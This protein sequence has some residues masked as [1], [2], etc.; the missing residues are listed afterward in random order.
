M[1][2]YLCED[3]I[4][5]IGT[6]IGKGAIGIVRISGKES[7]RILKE[8]FRSVRGKKIENFEPRKLYLGFVVDEFG[9]EIDQVLAVYMQ[10]PKSFT[11]EDLVEIHSH[12]GVVVV[13]KIL[14]EVLKR[15]ARLAEPGEFTMRAFI[16]GKIDLVQAEAINQLIEAKSEL[17]AEVA[18]KQLEGE[19]S[20]EIERI[21]DELLEVKAYIEAAVDFPEEEVEIIESGKV[22]EKLIEV[23]EKIEKLLKSYREGKIIKEG[24]KVAI[25]GRP[26]VGKSSLLNALLAEERAI[27]TEIP[28]TTRDVIEESITVKGIPLVLIDTAGIRETKELVEKIGIERSIEKLKESDVILFV[29][30]GSAELTQ[31]DGQIEEILKD[32]ENV[33]VVI[34][35][36]DRG[37]KFRC[38]HFKEKGWKCVEVSA[39][40]KEGIEEL[41]K[42]IVEMVLLEPAKVLGGEEAVITNERHKELLEKALKAVERTIESLERGFES[43]EFLSMD[44]D[45]ALEKLGMIV[46]KVTTEDM[47]DI[48]FSRFCIGK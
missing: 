22:K 31:E 24:I 6:P 3:T 37:L 25:V 40:E 16:N 8:M 29:V 1:R 4:A 36:K 27:V 35:K 9:K 32:K 34:N 15:G 45:Q 13:R 26:N 7:L 14:R 46:G 23:K 30:D 10:G 5:A 20:R 48:I 41:S 19:L 33:I 12:G 42:K 2:D 21:R 11:G 17:Q 28:G 39:K 44:I 38:S 47:Y 43:P 18:L